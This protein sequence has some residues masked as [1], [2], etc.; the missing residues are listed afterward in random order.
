MSFDPRLRRRSA[1]SFCQTSHYAGMPNFV[2]PSSLGSEHQM[3]RRAV[4]SELAFECIECVH[5][6]GFEVRNAGEKKR[7]IEWFRV[8]ARF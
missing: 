5:A 2:P 1:I 8:R 7:P 6:S 4:V 3:P